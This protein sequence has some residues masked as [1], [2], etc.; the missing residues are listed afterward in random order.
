M[1][2]NFK[3]LSA[4]IPRL[5]GKSRLRKQIISL[6]PDHTCYVEPFFGAGWVYFGK[7]PSKVEVINDID[8]ELINLFKMIKYHAEEIQRLMKYEISSRDLFNEYK[9]INITELTEIQRAVR[10][11]YLVS[12]SFAGK[13]GVYG[14]GTNT[15]PSPQIFETEILTKLKERL[16]NT[17]IE[18]LDYKVI[19]KKYD[20]EWTI[21]FCD[22]PYLDTDIKFSVDCKIKFDRDE[23][24]ELANILKNIKGKFLITINDHEFIRKLYEGFN[25]VETEVGYS[26]ARKNEG[27]R[28]YN[29]LIITNYG[30]S[31]NME[32][33]LE[34]AA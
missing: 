14:Y 19:L 28:K 26:V 31:Y 5:G 25:I 33:T 17:Y 3:M 1:K 10:Y 2:D 34:K 11:V 9:D 13:G 15:R 24:I 7:E 22:P 12:Q 16:R 29:E 6:L 32:K 4:P 30:K 21:F 23:H 8:G 18:N 20:R 27:R